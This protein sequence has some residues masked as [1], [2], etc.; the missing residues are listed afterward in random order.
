[1]INTKIHAS[2][3]EVAHRGRKTLQWAQEQ[4]RAGVFPAVRH[5]NDGWLVDREVGETLVAEWLNA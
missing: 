4:A 1:V 2:L 5:E 3:V